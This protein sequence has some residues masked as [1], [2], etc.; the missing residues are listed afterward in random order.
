MKIYEG[1]LILFLGL[2]L[3]LESLIIILFHHNYIEIVESFGAMSC[4]PG[5]I[6]VFLGIILLFGGPSIKTAKPTKEEIVLRRKMV[7][8]LILGILIGFIMGIFFS[9]LWNIIGLI[10]LCLAWLTALILRRKSITSLIYLFICNILIGYLTFSI[11]GLCSQ[12]SLKILNAP[13]GPL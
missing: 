11:I 6:L 13:R 7:F 2:F 4:P 10:L 3:I 1:K 5:I 9:P 8:G 12:L